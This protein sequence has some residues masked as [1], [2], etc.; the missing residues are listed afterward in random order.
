MPQKELARQIISAVCENTPLPVSLKIRAGVK[1][2]TAIDFI[3]D[4]KDLPFAA[5]MVHG[6]TYEG[7]FQAPV[8][9]AL[10]AKIKKLIPDKIVLANGG[11]N[12]PEDAFEILQKYPNIDGLGIA[13]GAWG[14]PYL[15]QQI[16]EIAKNGNYSDYDFKAIKKIMLRHAKL[17]WQ[18]KKDVGMFEIRKHLAWYVRGFPGAADLRR[19]LVQAK[20]VDEIKNILK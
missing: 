5:V 2:H 20:S 16:K 9:F 11:I 3:K 10:V 4:V 7:G 14:K 6:R 17:I 13:R 8:D 18:D 12:S 15:F 19:A 1:K